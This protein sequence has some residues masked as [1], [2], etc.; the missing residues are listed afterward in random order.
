M[1]PDDVIARS[2]VSVVVATRDRRA[3]LARTL[4]RL[5]ALRPRP[6]VI[7]VDNASSDGTSAFARR[8]FPDVT[9]VTL[10]ENR[11][12]AARNVG[13][14]LAETPYVAFS[15]DDS[16]WEP[17]ALERAAAV[18]GAHPRL[19]LVAAAVLVGDAARPDPVNELLA[20]GLP[21]G[22][23]PVPGPR[24]LGFLACAAVVRRAA[25]RQVGGFSDLLFFCGEEALLAQD[26]TAAGWECRHLPE[27]RAHHHPSRHR[28]PGGWRRRL[29][30]RN[31]VL[32]AWLR[33][34]LRRA[35]AETLGLARDAAADRDARR[36]LAGALRRLPAAV[37]DRRPLPR[38][39]E[40][41]LRLLE[42][43]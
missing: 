1:T 26:L 39:V 24:V 3:E 13:V 28:P 38:P 8:M 15:D 36:A 29:E 22:P 27:V 30:R 6:P 20:G 40:R 10:P 35:T 11:G 33:R 16:W 2:Q 12:A 25:F 42:A 32:T 37:L 31:T 19:G 41:D 23:G 21:A 34:P 7:V 43:R 9:V 4:G 18:L 14:E 17:G 5:T